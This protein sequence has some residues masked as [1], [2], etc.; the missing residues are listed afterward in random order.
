M[1]CPSKQL[2]L[3]VVLLSTAC[4]QGAQEPAAQSPGAT[5]VPSRTAEASPLPTPTPTPTP[6]PAP[7]LE[8]TLTDRQLAGQRI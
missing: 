5:D 2:A 3:A 7:V 8:R 6:T 4:G 1:L